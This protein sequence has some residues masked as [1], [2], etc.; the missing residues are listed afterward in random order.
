MNSIIRIKIIKIRKNISTAF[1][2]LFLIL[3]LRKLI[4]VLVKLYCI[5]LVF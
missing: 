4:I 2:F 5:L 3:F 1:T